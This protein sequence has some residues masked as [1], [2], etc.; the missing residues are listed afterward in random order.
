MARIS[1]AGINFSIDAS[2]RRWCCISRLVLIC[3][4]ER[5]AHG[6]THRF[7]DRPGGC[8]RR[9][10][11][12]VGLWREGV[13]V[14]SGTEQPGETTLDDPLPTTTRTG[15]GVLR[16]LKR[17]AAPERASRTPCSAAPGPPWLTSRP[18]LS[19]CAHG[20]AGFRLQTPGQCPGGPEAISYRFTT[21]RT[22]RAAY[23]E[24]HL[25]LH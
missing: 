24:C 22:A 1:N 7:A 3:K 13:R 15:R 8:H 21:V 11:H 12:H 9:I 2:G 6:N 18:A 19:L 10:L 20:N 16:Q 4:E 23:A 14:H 5:S 25:S 17:P